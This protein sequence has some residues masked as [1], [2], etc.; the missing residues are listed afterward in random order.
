M[1]RCRLDLIRVKS[2][3]N[4]KDVTPHDTVGMTAQEFLSRDCAN[5]ECSIAFIPKVHNGKYCS[6]E[7]RK[8]VTNKKVLENYYRRKKNRTTKRTCKTEGCK[9]ILSRYN[10]ENI[11][12][13][14][15]VERLKKRLVSWGW[16]RTKLDEDWSY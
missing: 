4:V 11:C 3:H 10:D 16:S 1:E 2:R 9:T 7:C 6:A 12:E 14:C 5:E 15:K 8:L 13:A